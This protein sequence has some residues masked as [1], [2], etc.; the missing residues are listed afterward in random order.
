[1]VRVVVRVV[2]D[3]F[4]ERGAAGVYLLWGRGGLGNEGWHVLL[5][6]LPR[7]GGGGCEHVSWVCTSL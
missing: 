6:V 4:S 1:M 2:K 5:M 3:I 7:V